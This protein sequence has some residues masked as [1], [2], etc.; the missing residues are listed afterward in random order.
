MS[1]NTKTKK[2]IFVRHGQAEHNVGYL[3]YGEEAYFSEKYKNSPL[4]LLGRK[5]A[6]ELGNFMKSQNILDTI[7]LVITSPLER[8]LQTTNLITTSCIKK[9]KIIAIEHAREYNYHHPCNERKTKSEMIKAY[10]DINF[11]L[12]EHEDDKIFHTGDTIDRR[13]ALMYYIKESE[14]DTIMVVSHASFLLSFLNKFYKTEPIDEIGNCE[15]VVKY[16]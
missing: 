10:G 2:V 11:S 6:H 1:I 4:T 9:P 8:T 12:I 14:G 7:D 16:I 3:N 5:Q 15:F 13:D